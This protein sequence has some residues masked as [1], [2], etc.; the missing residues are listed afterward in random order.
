VF[1][2]TNKDIKTGQ[3]FQVNRNQNR[4][5]L[6]KFIDKNPMRKSKTSAMDN[7]CEEIGQ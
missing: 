4:L 1:V 6:V 2:Y 7:H 3:V 5:E